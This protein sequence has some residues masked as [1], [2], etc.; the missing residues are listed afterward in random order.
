MEASVSSPKKIPRR[1]KVATIFV[2]LVG[3][4]CACL[5]TAG[6]Q[7]KPHFYVRSD[8]HV[9]IGDKRDK[10]INPADLSK[11]IEKLRTWPSRV[12]IEADPDLP[13]EGIGPLLNTT[14]ELGFARYQLRSNERSLNFS[15]PG[16]DFDEL[17]NSRPEF[18]DLRAKP[19]PEPPPYNMYSGVPQSGDVYVAADGT[20]P[21]GELLS[22]LSPKLKSG[23]TMEIHVG[24]SDLFRWRDEDKEFPDHPNPHLPKPIWT[25]AVDYVRDWF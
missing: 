7:S 21:C 14:A 20:I 9:F 23:V 10:E 3:V 16:G 2:L 6:N 11:H 24:N 5:L 17:G 4:T 18:I 8:G 12:V 15:V 1:W 25:R 19:T 22:R 13:F